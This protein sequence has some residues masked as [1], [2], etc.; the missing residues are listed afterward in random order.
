MS[1]RWWHRSSIRPPGGRGTGSARRRSPMPVRAG[2]RSHPDSLGG[3]AARRPED[4]VGHRSVPSAGSARSRAPGRAPP[5]DGRPGLL[6]HERLVVHR[7]PPA[8]VSSPSGLTTCRGYRQPRDAASVVRPRSQTHTS[9]VQ[10]TSGGVGFSLLA[11][12]ARHAPHPPYRRTPGAHPPRA[13]PLTFPCR[14]THGPS[15]PH[16]PDLSSTRAP[17]SPHFRPLPT[18]THPST[19]HRAHLTPPQLTDH[20]STSTQRS[21]TPT[22][23]ITRHK[24]H[25]PQYQDPDQYQA[26][27]DAYALD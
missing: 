10:L 25:R 11:R 24:I 3:G 6:G 12:R 22:L 2:S 1:R 21:T 20:T 23:T 17:H 13:R 4:N 19:R 5:T 27:A 14:S 26:T 8:G 7:R 18:A 9:R 16:V 15:S